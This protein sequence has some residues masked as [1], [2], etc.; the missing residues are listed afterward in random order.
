VPPKVRRGRTIPEGHTGSPARFGPLPGSSALQDGVLLV[1]AIHIRSR[2]LNTFLL[3]GY[4]AELR[5]FRRAEH[6][7]AQMFLRQAA[8][9]ST[10][11]C[12]CAGRVG[13]AVCDSL[14][15]AASI[16]TGRRESSA[17]SYIECY[18]Q[19]CRASSSSS[20][21]AKLCACFGVTIIFVSLLISPGS[22]CCCCSWN[23]PGAGMWFAKC[24]HGEQ[25]HRRFIPCDVRLYSRGSGL[26]RSRFASSC[27]IGSDENVFHCATE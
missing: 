10:A 9:E 24:R 7:K 3:V 25:R 27:F 19:R 18:G 2:F 11:I 23:P 22:S 8:T 15:T 21:Q 17:A 12:K 5:N 4:S 6:F 20:P 16:T 14:S 1:G 26:A 13:I